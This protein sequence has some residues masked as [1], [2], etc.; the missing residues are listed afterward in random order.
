MK[1]RLTIGIPTHGRAERCK[2]AISSALWQDEPA[3]LIVAD[4]SDGEDIERMMNE[5]RNHPLVSY[6]R[7][8]AKS[9]W[10]NWRF[11]AEEAVRDGATFFA[12]LQDDD[13][14]GKW[15][16][17]R[18]NRAFDQFP[19]ALTYCSSL[20]TAYN[21]LLGVRWSG[22]QGPRLAL[23]HLFENP[24][25]FDAR[26]LVPI[27]YTDAWAM[28]PAKAFR[29]GDVFED[30]LAALPD[31]CD[32]LTEVLD[33]AY[34]GLHGRAIADPRFAGYWMFHDSNESAIRNRD[35]KAKEE[36]PVA[37]EFLDSLMDQNPEWRGILGSWIA[38]MGTPDILEPYCKTLSDRRGLS[39][40]ADQIHDMYREVLDLRK[41]ASTRESVTCQ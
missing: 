16:C 19:G 25:T 40:Y 31:H 5:Y 10:Q 37:W 3:R 33:V 24:I 21:N 8:P 27:G 22:N 7:S 9:L 14:I 41:S 34:M 6:V 4:D 20:I 30:M 39:L 38:F 35:D 15:L 23:D 12:W 11:V 17:R 29:V 28:A 32:L 26:L 1:P 13:V 18:I 2:T 36:V